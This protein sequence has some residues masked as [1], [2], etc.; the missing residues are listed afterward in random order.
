MAEFRKAAVNGRW[1]GLM[2]MAVLLALVWPLVA[3]FF[4]GGLLHGGRDSRPGPPPD[5]SLIL[6]YTPWPVFGIARSINIATIFPMIFAGLAVTNEIKRRKITAISDEPDRVGGLG[7][8]MIAYILWGTIFGIVIVV[9]VGGGTVIVA[10]TDALPN[11]SDGLALAGAGVLTSVLM[12]MFGAGV[13]ALL[14]KPT[15]TTIVL[16]LYMLIIEN[17]ILYLL[18][19]Q[20]WDPIG[21]IGFLPNG[22]A[23]GITASVATDL[24]ISAGSWSPE[25]ASSTFDVYVLFAGAPGAFDWWLSGLVFLAWT[26]IFLLGGWAV[27][28]KKVT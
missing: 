15:A 28:R 6:R 14:R 2:I 3:D 21:I 12:T 13:G 7:A 19:T 25:A 24:F 23:N 17:G 9:A 11:T 1:L 10:N 27:R 20:H 18:L 8:K 4:L 5:P 16:V 26:G 22:S